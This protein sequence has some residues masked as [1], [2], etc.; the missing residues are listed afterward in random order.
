MVVAV[1]FPSTQSADYNTS[2]YQAGGFEKGMYKILV[3]HMAEACRKL[4]TVNH[5]PR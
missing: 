3:L 4:L 5:Q 1:E 2:R